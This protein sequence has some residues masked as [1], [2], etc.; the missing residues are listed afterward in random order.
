MKSKI[1]LQLNSS[2]YETASKALFNFLK[3]EFINEADLSLLLS[4]DNPLI[5]GDFLEE[6][7]NFNQSD[8][9]LI[10]NYIKGNLNNLN[11]LFVSDLIEFATNWSL[12]L[13]YEICLKFLKN[14]GND[15]DYVQLASLD[16]IYENLK[17]NYIEE[18]YNSLNNI[19]SNPMSN[20]SSQVKSAFILFRITN[21]KNFLVDLIDLVVHGNEYNKVLLSNILILKHNNEIYFEDYNLLKATITSMSNLARR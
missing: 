19:L 21:K 9:K 3:V 20:Q 2:N 12:E 8:L 6:Y 14:F 16:Y 10:E 1:F 18:I 17:F 11:K 13:P 5:I 15:D 7:K 4:I